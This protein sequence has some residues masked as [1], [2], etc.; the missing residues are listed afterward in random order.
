MRNPATTFVDKHDEGVSRDKRWI[1]PALGGVAAAIILA[2]ILKDGFCHYFS[3]FG[4]CGDSSRRDRL[5]EE[6]S[7]LNGAVRTI[8][9]ESG[10]K[11]HLLGHSLNKTQT[12][13]K[14]TS[15][16]SN[17]NFELFRGILLNLVN[18][19]DDQRNRKSACNQYQWAS[20][21]SHAVKFSNVVANH[22]QTLGTIRAELIAY[23]MAVHNYGYILDALARGE[24]TC[25]RICTGNF[26][27]PG[28]PVLTD[29]LDGIYLGKFQEAIPRT[30]F[31]TYYA[32]ELVQSTVIT[33]TGINVLVN[34]PIH[35]TMG[36][37]EV[38][39]AI[40][41]P[42]P[43]DGGTTATQCRFSSTHLLVSERRDNFAEVSGD[44]IAAHC[45]GSNRL[46]LCLRQFA[47]SRSSESSCLASFFFGLPTTAL[48]LC[49]Q[50]V[51]VLPETPSATYLEDSTY[52]VTS[53]DDDYRLFNYSRGAKE[54]GQPVP[55]RSV[56]ENVL[57]EIA[58]PFADEILRKHTPF[59]WQM[60]RSRPVR[61]WIVI[62]VLVTIVA[63]F[64]C[65][66]WRCFSK[67]SR[68]AHVLYRGR[69]DEDPER[70]N[71]CG[72]MMRESRQVLPPK[73]DPPYD[74]GAP[75]P[76]IY[77]QGPSRVDSFNGQIYL[78]TRFPE[79]S[80]IDEANASR[81]T[82][83]SDTTSTPLMGRG[84]NY[85]RGKWRGVSGR[86][87]RIGTSAMM[88]NTL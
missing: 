8:V 43:A 29:I 54:S 68:Y 3:F 42:Q 51:I 64:A 46:K 37:H 72:L 83:T 67:N 11:L 39:R 41:L 40:S 30:E 25:P 48:R 79:S 31:M 59:H 81:T 38:Y 6:V 7:F 26:G 23:K 84:I 1:K 47:M 75:R 77:P 60:L 76:N 55:E 16:D 32:F 33:E 66:Y 78:P 5:G 24:R 49:P 21:Y 34:I 50:E 17:T 63:I 53:R 58:T 65:V 20:I 52:L 86:G 70:S 56:D 88:D 9:L 62:W 61:Y 27:T 87:P 71:C 19:T 73:Y 45:S 69:R 80:S 22:S 2:P 35:H 82:G 12:Q 4:L 44:V 74:R 13:L 57:A 18:E 14:V 10:E 85:V 36:V 28:G 15:H